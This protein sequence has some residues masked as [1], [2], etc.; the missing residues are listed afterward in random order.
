VGLIVISSHGQTADALGFQEV[1]AVVR[2]NLTRLSEAEL[3][4][5][6]VMGLLNE[7]KGQAV[8]V[9]NETR[10]T[11]PEA[12][13]PL[14][15]KATVFDD[16]YGYIRI[17][18]VSTGLEKAFDSV[19]E[20]LST[21]KLKGLMIDLRFSDGHD[22]SAVA[23]LASR[24]I[25]SEQPLF[26]LGE[27]NFRS[28]GRENPI[29]LPIAALVN[30]ETS[31]SAEVLAA[32]LRQLEAGLLIGGATAGQAHSF[33]AFPLSNGWTLKIASGTVEL[34]GGQ[35]LTGQ[36]VIPDIRL[37]VSAADERAYLDDP[38]W[39]AG[40]T[41]GQTSLRPLAGTVHMGGPQ[42]R[43]GRRRLNEAELVRMQREGFDL[44]RD[45]AQVAPDPAKPTVQDPTLGRALDFLKGMAVAQSRR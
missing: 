29:K 9:T 32:L 10:T 8:L 1:Y 34:A 41:S 27:R 14:I 19:L 18:R 36:G 44:N 17:A 40:Q 2:S 45:A 33:T 24:F 11:E 3:N 43:A 13:A 16:A 4:R 28:V 5:A 42:N 26:K 6:A 38:Y 15:S 31:G 20:Q 7:L 22:Y 12:S 35:V 39:S 23:E 25:E 21:N 37:T 30:R